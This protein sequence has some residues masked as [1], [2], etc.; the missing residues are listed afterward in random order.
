MFNGEYITVYSHRS[1][2]IN[3]RKKLKL[4]KMLEEEGNVVWQCPSKYFNLFLN[5]AQ[6]PFDTHSNFIFISAG[7]RPRMLAVFVDFLRYLGRNINE[8]LLEDADFLFIADRRYILELQVMRQL[9]DLHIN[10]T[11]RLNR[12]GFFQKLC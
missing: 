3:D 7:D 5:K 11:N 6:P 2:S 9:G 4:E 1:G 10:V 8:F 12:H